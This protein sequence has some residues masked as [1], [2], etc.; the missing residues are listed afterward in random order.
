MRIRVVELTM[1]PSIY[2]VRMFYSFTGWLLLTCLRPLY[3][4]E[5]AVHKRYFLPGLEFTVANV[6]FATGSRTF[7]PKKI[8]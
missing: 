4:I 8:T 3:Q 7:A 6:Q 5:V 2:S 1:N